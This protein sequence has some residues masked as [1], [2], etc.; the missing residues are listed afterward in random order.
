MKVK[1]EADPKH[2]LIVEGVEIKGGKS[3][4]VSDAAGKRLIADPEI[5]VTELPATEPKQ[6]KPTAAGAGQTKKE[7]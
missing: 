4:D 5:S 3:A 1:Y 7:K 2:T 6:P